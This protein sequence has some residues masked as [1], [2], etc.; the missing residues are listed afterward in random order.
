MTKEITPYQPTGPLADMST[1]I[2]DAH[3]LAMVHAGEAMNNALRCGDLLTKAKAAAKHGQWLPWLRQNIAFSERTAQSYMRLAAKFG[4]DKRNAVA[5]LSVRRVL[6]EIA[7]PRRHG[8]VDDL[9]AWM[10]RTQ[11]T[12][13]KRPADST[14]WDIE[15]A[16]ACIKD[17]REFDE[18]LHVHGVCAGDDE[19][20]EL[21]L[22][23]CRVGAGEPSKDI[24]P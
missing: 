4:P 3:A 18:I 20:S 11:P 7:T 19:L 16:I 9:V 2:N 8:L 1:E 6:Q 12:R 23:C 24:C 22:V 10:E 15:D 17:M 13:D 14:A 5:D 21:C